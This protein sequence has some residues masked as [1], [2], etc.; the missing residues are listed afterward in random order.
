VHINFTEQGNQSYLVVLK[1]L[2]VFTNYSIIAAAYSS[3][4]VG[5]LRQIFWR[6]DQGEPEVPPSNFEVKAINSSHLNAS[7]SMT[8]DIELLNGWFISNYSIAYME[9]S[10][11]SLTS[12]GSIVVDGSI[13]SVIIGPLNP[14]RE[15]R[16][17]VAGNVESRPGVFTSVCV[18]TDE[19]GKLLTLFPCFYSF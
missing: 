17:V 8:D 10:L 6:T 5:S 14:W 13:M 19:D 1:D 11:P 16:V 12:S 18:R 3:A 2:D 4:G 15:Y 7:W 9:Y